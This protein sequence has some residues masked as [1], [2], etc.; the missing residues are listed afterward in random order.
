MVRTGTMLKEEQRSSAVR[1]PCEKVTIESG[2]LEVNFDQRRQGGDL[3]G[4]VRAVRPAA[5][6]QSDWRRQ[7]YVEIPIDLRPTPIAN[8][9]QSRR[10]A[11]G[12]PTTLADVV[13][14]E[15]QCNHP[16]MFPLEEEFL[17]RGGTDGEPSGRRRWRRARTRPLRERRCPAGACNKGG[18]R[19][20]GNRRTSSRHVSQTLRSPSSGV[21][22]GSSW[23]STN[24]PALSAALRFSRVEWVAADHRWMDDGTREEEG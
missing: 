15:P 19:G 10:Y 8:L 5:Y 13:A 16:P 22:G 21:V 9:L 6:E 3:T 14:D 20:R 1:I 11:V 17:C 24:L 18:S 2:F 4:S 12:K 23:R 7:D